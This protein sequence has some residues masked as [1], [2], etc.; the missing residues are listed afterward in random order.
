MIPPPFAGLRAIRAVELSVCRGVGRGRHAHPGREP[1]AL[2]L[3]S[4]AGPTPA[5]P[6]HPQAG[7]GQGYLKFRRG[8]GVSPPIRREE[9]EGKGLLRGLQDWFG[10]RF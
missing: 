1:E 9:L 8:G 4:G 5:E 7:P 2:P 6:G 3:R 10:W